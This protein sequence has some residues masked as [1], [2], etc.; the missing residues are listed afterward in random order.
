M[1][2]G[3]RARPWDARRKLAI[4]CLVLA[5][6]AVAVPTAAVAMRHRAESTSLPGQPDLRVTGDAAHT[7][8]PI[9]LSTNQRSALLS[10]ANDAYQLGLQASPNDA[11]TAKEAFSTAAEKYQLLVDSGIQN[12]ELYCNLGNA[13]LQSGSLGRAIA[14]YE[15]ALV[16]DPSNTKAQTNLGAARAEISSTIA[17]SA[18]ETSLR[19][20][21]DAA[22]ARLRRM[23]TST[24]G[25]GLLATTWILA[26][27]SVFTAL[28]LPGR[29]WRHA[30]ILATCLLLLCLALLGF[31]HLGN[32]QHA[33]AIVAIRAAT[34]RQAPGDSFAAITNERLSEGQSLTVL[35][36]RDSWLQVQTPDGQ[37]GWIASPQIEY[38]APPQSH[39]K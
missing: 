12:S 19:R 20:T 38:V 23:L 6:I 4:E 36:H 2:G 35:R 11:A 8:A 16:M 17:D 7:D 15:R 14:N 31:D 9:R 10:E 13:Y 26:W 33:H 18:A 3:E 1:T 5:A 28:Y 32:P 21:F 27:A 30:L 24:A 34:L 39:A 29:R 22:V 37:T 25:K